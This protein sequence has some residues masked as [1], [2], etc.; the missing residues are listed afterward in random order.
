[1]VL[2][3][4]KD[5]GIKSGVNDKAYSK[6]KN[7]VDGIRKIKGITPLDLITEKVNILIEH[8]SF[9]NDMDGAI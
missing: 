4:L 6:L 7:I 9:I 1:M 5:I 3:S 8:I 2:F